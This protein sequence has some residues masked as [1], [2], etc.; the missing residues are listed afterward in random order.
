MHD[1]LKYYCHRWRDKDPSVQR[2][3]LLEAKRRFR[4]TAQW[5]SGVLWA[6]WITVAERGGEEADAWRLIEAA[7][8]VSDGI[9]IDLDGG[10]MSEGMRRERE[11]AELLGKHVEVLTW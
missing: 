4:E 5:I 10:E 11:I 8:A 2:W 1:S 6:P 7:I 3:N 9:V